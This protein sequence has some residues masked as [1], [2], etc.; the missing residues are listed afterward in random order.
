VSGSRDIA[1]DIATGYGLDDRGIGVLVAVGSGI[2]S[3]PRRPLSLLSSGVGVLSPGVKQ[4]A[5]DVDD[6][7]PTSAKVKIR[8]CIHP[9]PH[10]SSWRN[11]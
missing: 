6:S 4:P 3:S 5:P 9:L 2:Y 8:R 7:P 1:V 11:A 10:T